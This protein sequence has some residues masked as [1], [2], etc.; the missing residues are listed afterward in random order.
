MDSGY[1]I[2]DDFDIGDDD[3][4]LMQKYVRLGPEHSKFMKMVNVSWDI[5]APQYWWKEMNSYTAKTVRDPYSITH[6][7]TNEEFTLDDFSIEKLYKESLLGI[8][9][10]ITTLNLWRKAYLAEKD[11]T[12][13][14]N[15]WYQIIQ[16]LPSSYNE[17]ATIQ[18]NYAELYNIYHAQKELN[19][20]PENHRLDEWYIFCEWVKA[21]PLGKELICGFDVV[22]PDSKMDF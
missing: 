9:S 10:V 17:C 18:L 20:I 11:V 1:N 6:K 13:K 21:L 3:L 2:F 22:V 7:I 8:Q 16:L 4:R 5:T 15:I 14:N 19:N 12:T